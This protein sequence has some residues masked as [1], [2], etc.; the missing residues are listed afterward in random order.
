[1]T[2]TTMNWKRWIGFGC[3]RL[4]SWKLPQLPTQSGNI[5]VALTL[6]GFSSF[7]HGFKEGYHLELNYALLP[8]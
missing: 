8:S 1:M 2:T 5:A 7:V 4:P 6:L 3:G